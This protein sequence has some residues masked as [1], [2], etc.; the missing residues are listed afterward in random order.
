[1][2]T[3]FHVAKQNNILGQNFHVSR[4]GSSLSY[5]GN[6]PKML[7]LEQNG[8][9]LFGDGFWRL[10]C[11]STHGKHAHQISSQ[12]GLWGLILLKLLWSDPKKTAALK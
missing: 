5:T 6:D 9:F 8:R 2:S 12:K 4:R 1:M 10:F 3:K 11:G 7:D